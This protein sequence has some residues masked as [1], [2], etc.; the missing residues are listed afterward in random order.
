MVRV[1]KP[2]GLL[3]L[4]VP[5]ANRDVLHFNAHRVFN[6]ITIINQVLGAE[7][8]EFRYIKNMNISKPIIELAKED[9]GEY[10]CGLF[11]F[12]KK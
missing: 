3:Y 12:R 11:I 7:L 4:A 9:Y 8:L 5:I 1:L 2:K 10:S 6:P